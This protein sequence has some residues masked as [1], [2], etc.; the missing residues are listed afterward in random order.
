LGY[1]TFYQPARVAVDMQQRNIAPGSIVASYL[2]A[3][4]ASTQTVASIASDAFIARL[5]SGNLG[6]FSPSFVSRYGIIGVTATGQS[7][8]LSPPSPPPSPPTPPFVYLSVPS[9]SSNTL[10]IAIGVGVGGGMVLIITVALIFYYHRTRHRLTLRERVEVACQQYLL[11]TTGDSLMIGG[12]IF[13]DER[14]F[15]TLEQQGSAATAVSDT[16]TRMPD[17][18]KKDNMRVLHIE[19]VLTWDKMVVYEEIDSKDVLELSYS[20]AIKLNIWKSLLILS[21]RWG[22][23]KPDKYEVS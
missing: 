15:L 13:K 16:E 23:P 14:D 2:V 7:T 6:D 11:D 5:Q 12:Q 10:S 4:T 3:I 19:N 21:W 9:A 22:R 18:V 17:S 20:D 8:T 1:F